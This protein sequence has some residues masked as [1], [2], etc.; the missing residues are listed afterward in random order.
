VAFSACLNLLVWRGGVEDWL[1]AA[2]SHSACGPLLWWVNSAS[3][4][5]ELMPDAFLLSSSP[6][7]SAPTPLQ[8]GWSQMRHSCTFRSD[9]FECD[10]SAAHASPPTWEQNRDF[11]SPPQGLTPA[12]LGWGWSCR[13]DLQLSGSVISEWWTNNNIYIILKWTWN[14]RLSPIADKWSGNYRLRRCWG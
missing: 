1:R 8:M 4:H 7:L 2:W 12:P 14:H 13:K 6:A 9:V 3:G 11:V 5:K 10:G